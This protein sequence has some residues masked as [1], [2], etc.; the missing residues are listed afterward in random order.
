VSTLENFRKALRG[1]D[2]LV[3]DT[4][5]TGLDNAEVVQIAIINSA[6]EP[7]LDTLV[8]TKQP[9]PRDATRIHGITDEMVKDCPTWL[10]LAPKIKTILDGQLLVVYNATFDREIM[11]QTAERWDLP[12][13]EWKEICSWHCAMEAYAEFYGEWNNYHGNYRWQRLGN[14]ARNCNLPTDDAHDALAD[15]LMA[16]GV[17][18]HM[19]KS[20]PES[21]QEPDDSYGDGRDYDEEN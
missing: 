11:H 2:F 17:T 4:E 6:G 18:K 8:K 14:A 19:L 16:L 20:E 10:D 3:L 5:T 12:K 7:L 13:I 9:I 21:E 1:K 15:C